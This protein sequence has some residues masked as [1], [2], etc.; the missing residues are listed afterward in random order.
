[1]V[2]L[3][4][5]VNR[6]LTPFFDLLC[7]PFRSLPPIWAMLVISCLSGVAMVWIFGKTSDQDR[8]RQLREQIRGNLIGVRLFQRD[9][10]VILRLQRRIFGDTLRYMRLALVPMVVLL[11]PVLL[12][13][14]AAQSALRGP[15]RSR[16]ARRR[17]SRR[18]SATRTSLA[19]PARLEAGSGITVETPAVRMPSASE[20]AWRIRADA[21]GEHRLVVHVGDASVETHLI[22]GEGW[23]PVPD[24]RTGRG[25]IDT[26][27]YPG[28]PPIAG[29]HVVAAV[30]IGYAAL[31]MR[32]F[33]W[34]LHWLVAFF[35]L[36][37]VFGY[38][39]KG[40]LGVEL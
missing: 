5:A 31:D 8:I 36:S 34:P 20:V 4:D 16:R 26:L 38:A 21:A 28:Q 24:R 25:V 17:W 35:V 1:M 13:M 6:G 2:T 37:I 40:R 32:A 22:A 30:E 14:D 15:A 10:G 27:L 29:D 18:S 11:V 19:A 3:V 23:G 9:V 7:W 39:L 33:G 12:I